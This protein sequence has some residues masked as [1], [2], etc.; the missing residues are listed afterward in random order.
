MR[1]FKLEIDG[2]EK[3]LGFKPSLFS[4]RHKVFLDGLPI[5]E[6]ASSKEAT[7]GKEFRIDHNNFVEIKFVKVALNPEVH[8][9]LNGLTLESSPNHP[10]ARKTAAFALAVFLTILNLG[11]GIAGASGVFPFLINAGFGIYNLIIGIFYL[12]SLALFK[13]FDPF[14]GIVLCLVLYSIDSIVAL[15]SLPGNPGI[16]GAI[17]V[18]IMFFT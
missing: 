6:F 10:K 16:S 9:S 17:I 12:M 1:K 15:N 18:R 5:G 13:F 3:I 7:K 14:I 4:S 8:V 11:I 2:K